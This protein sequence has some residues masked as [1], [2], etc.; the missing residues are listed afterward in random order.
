RQRIRGLRLFLRWNHSSQLYLSQI[1]PRLSGS[2]GGQYNRLL[3]RQ[4]R[5]SISIM[6][7]YALSLK[8]PW[9]ALLAH[10]LKTIEVRRWPTARRGKVLIHAALVPDERPHAWSKVPP[11]L[12]ETAELRRGIIRGG[13]PQHR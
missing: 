4:R 1:T 7:H 8:Q 5:R 13:T 10:G 9:A 12:P 2:G 11:K 6:K 3:S